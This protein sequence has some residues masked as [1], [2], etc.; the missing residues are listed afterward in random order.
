[1]LLRGVAGRDRHE[2]VAELERL[3]WTDLD[4]SARRLRQRQAHDPPAVDDVDREAE[5]E[6]A[7]AGVARTGALDDDH[8]PRERRRDAAEDGE[9]GPVDTARA[10]VRACAERELLVA[11][12]PAELD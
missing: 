3:R 8:Q 10:E 1:R 9:D 5:H 11:A 4:G 7:E 6:P 12:T 2:D